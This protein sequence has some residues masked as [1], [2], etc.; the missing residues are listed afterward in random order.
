MAAHFYVSSQ[1]MQGRQPVWAE[2]FS[3]Q[4]LGV[5]RWAGLCSHP[6]CTGPTEWPQTRRGSLGGLAPPQPPSPVCPAEV[7][8]GTGATARIPALTPMLPA[9]MGGLT[10]DPWEQSYPQNRYSAVLLCRPTSAGCPQTWKKG[11]L[12]ASS[13]RSSPRRK[14]HRMH[15]TTQRREPGAVAAGPQESSLPPRGAHYAR[16]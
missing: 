11:P 7:G 1:A 9:G 16:L 8:M 3:S 4:H 10:C 5:G 14:Q 12:P 13:L 6:L 15:M 2:S